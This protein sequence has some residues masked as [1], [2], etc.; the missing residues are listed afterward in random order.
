MRKYLFAVL[1]FWMLIVVGHA[2]TVSQAHAYEKDARMLAASVLAQSEQPPKLNGPEGAHILRVLNSMRLRGVYDEMQAVNSAE[3]GKRADDA[4]QKLSQ[5]IDHLKIILAT[6]GKA[7]KNQPRVYGNEYLL[8]FDFQIDLLQMQNKMME[9]SAKLQTN[10]NEK[11]DPALDEAM[12]KM[13]ASLQSL[14]NSLALIQVESLATDIGSGNF[15][16]ELRQKALMTLE[17]NMA[18]LNSKISPEKSAAL[19]RK[20]N[21]KP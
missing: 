9:N 19:M 15:P 17:R 16:P 14:M 20:A 7:F 10:T 2:Q 18:K 1:G 6:Y 13:M 3:S 21:A 11:K 4:A 5:S 8:S 12:V